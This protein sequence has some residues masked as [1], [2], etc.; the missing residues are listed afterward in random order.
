MPYIG[1]SP[2]QGVRRVHTYT[3]TANQTSFS[4]AGAEGATLSY[5]DSNFVDV[6]QNGVKLGDADYTATSGTAIVLGTGAT[7]SDLVVIVAYDV[8][9]AADTVS[10]ADGGQFDGNVTMAGTLGVTGV[11]TGTSLDISGNIDIDGTANLDVVDIDGAVDMASTLQVDGAITSSAGATITTADNSNNLTL[12][13]TDA[14]AST[15]PNLVLQ[16]DSASPADN[17]LSGTIKFIADND[18]AEATDCV[19]I[20]SK[21]I[22]ASNGSEDAS[23]LINSI[24]GG[25]QIS[26]FNITP[27]EIAINDDSVDLDFR[28][29]SNGNANMLFVDGGND[30]VG[31]GIVPT[32]RL[33]LPAQASGDSGIARFAIESAVDSNDFT[34]AQYEDSTGTYTQI[35]QNVSLNSGGSTTVLDSGHR[36]ASMFF[37][38]RGNGALMFHTGG[39]NANAERMRIDSSG[40]HRWQHT[41]GD[42]SAFS[43]SAVGIQFTPSGQTVSATIGNTGYVNRTNYSSGTI[44]YNIFMING[45]S[46]VGSISYNGSSTS[47]TTS[48]DY[49]LKESIS[50]DFDAT[51]RLKQ[52]KPCRFV[53]KESLT[54]Q[55]VDGFLAHEVSSIVP[56]AITGEKDGVE[57]VG[58]VKTS[59]G[60]VVHTDIPEDK[61]PLEENQ[62]WTKTGTKPV[63]QQIDQAKL[64]P[65]LVKTIQELEA[66]ITALESA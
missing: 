4:G 43:S 6:Y 63:H 29:E 23:L 57:D 18:A 66:R 24:V 38:G 53:F 42:P 45:S 44:Y 49:R 39:T 36:T 48:S 28:V 31:I 20:F 55:T 5:K 52:L 26:R 34:I 51:T 3:A 60:T 47:Y 17:D 13:S 25:S 54:G 11:L 14:D 64:V 61:F 7:V 32:A 19:S 10:K 16:R 46:T 65:L 30:K 22:D 50:Y 58:T 12:I 33:S 21:I 59:D 56:E 1:T 8:F 37:D 15:G 62:T 2:S 9:S 35:G 27:L 41:S 40:N